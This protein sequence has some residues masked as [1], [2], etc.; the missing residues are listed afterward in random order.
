MTI[1]RLKTPMKTTF[2]TVLL[3]CASAVTVAQGTV[4]PAIPRDAALEAKVEKTLA[5]NSPR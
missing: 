4:K 5:K 2:L 3:A 1:N